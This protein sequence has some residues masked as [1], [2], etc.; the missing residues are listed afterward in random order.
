METPE[1]RR[2]CFKVLLAALSAPVYA[3]VTITFLAPSLKSPQPIGTPVIWTAKATDTNPGPLT[4]QFNVAAPGQTFALVKDFNVGTLRTGT[5]Q[6]FVW[7][8]TGVEGRYQIQ[9]VA[10]D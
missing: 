8:S 3:S 2:W 6:P 5:S 4:F 9:V 10:K 7:V 1:I